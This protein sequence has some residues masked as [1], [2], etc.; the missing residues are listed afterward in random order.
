MELE[1]LEG[2]KDIVLILGVSLVTAGFCIG[3]GTLGYKLGERQCLVQKFKEYYREGLIKKKPNIFN[4]YKITE[5][6]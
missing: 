3:A 1:T 5:K 2:L 6:D 4:I